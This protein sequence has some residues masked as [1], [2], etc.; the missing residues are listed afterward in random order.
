MSS[1]VANPDAAKALPSCSGVTYPAFAKALA[2]SSGVVNLLLL[3]LRLL[4][5]V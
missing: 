2:T 3:L 5:Q 1:G 4:L